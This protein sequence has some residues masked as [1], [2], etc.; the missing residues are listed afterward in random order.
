MDLIVYLDGVGDAAARGGGGRAGGAGIGPLVL[1]QV[2]D[3]W[4]T[5]LVIDANVHNCQT[6]SSVLEKR[7][8]IY[9]HKG[10]VVEIQVF[11]YI[12][13]NF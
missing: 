4:R 3:S 9:I 5:V 8:E 13:Q 1:G 2:V 6:G 12:H 11:R 10:M 7:L